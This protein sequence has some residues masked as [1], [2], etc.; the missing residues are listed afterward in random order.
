LRVDPIIAGFLLAACAAIPDQNPRLAERFVPPMTIEAVSD[1]PVKIG[2]S[3]QV[4]GQRYTPADTADYEQ[5]GLASWY[6]DEVRGHRTSNGEAFNPDG[7]SAAHPT[8]PIPS[9]VEVTSLDTGRTILVRVN[10]RGPFHSSRILDLSIGAARQLGMTGR[11]ERPMRVRRVYPS[12]VEKFALR[13]GQ[14]VAERTPSSSTQLAILRGRTEWRLPVVASVKLPMGSGPF[15]LQVASFSS[16]LR[17][18]SMAKRLKAA[19]SPL[20]ANY[21]V[22]LGPYESAREA[23]AALAPLAAKGYPDVRIVQ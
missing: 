9:Y 12:D 10:D 21:R 4:A 19:I 16:S 3:Y 13:N 14:S 6:G 1:S 18:A 5:I 15:Y 23:N 17:A 22:R 11:G 7:I 2:I 20:G 8:L